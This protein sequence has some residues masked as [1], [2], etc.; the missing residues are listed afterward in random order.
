[1]IPT[2]SDICTK[3][4]VS[5][6][7]NASI[8]DAI[9]LMGSKNVRSVVILE[10]EENHCF[11]F[12]INNAIEYKI[13][14]LPMDTKLIDLQLHKAQNIDANISILEL[15]NHRGLDHEYF[16][17]FKEKEIIGI[18]SQTDIIN[19]ID[20]QMLLQKQS[21]ASIMLQYTVQTVYA[22]EA[23]INAIKIMKNENIDSVIIIDNTHQ[24]IGIFTTKDFL[25][26]VSE[27]IDLTLPI[28]NYMSFPLE[29]LSKDVKIYEALE[30][31]RKKRFK[32]L[33]VT[34][35]NSKIS[36]VITQSELLR[37]IN[38][39]WMEIIRD[40]GVELSKQNEELMKKA[41]RLEETAS[42]DF[43]TKLFNRRKF[44]ALLQYEIEQVK[45]YQKGK[46]SMILLDID[47]FKSINDTYGHDIGDEILKE[48]GLMLKRLSRNS[49]V[50]SRWGGEEFALNLS[51][52]PIEDALFVAEKLRASIQEHIFTQNLRITCS[53][54]V[55]QFRTSDELS[56]LFKRADEA[57][58]EAK[59]TGK[60]K[61]VLERL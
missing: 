26:I 43:L 23:T 8:E 35:E 40:R 28:K 3:E 21:I 49:D 25:N 30:F 55:S 4:I 56:D 58:Y 22:N 37:L 5:I 12:S 6:D 9:K 1:M 38:N 33:I 24:P 10:Q 61:V 15:T 50:V 7:I 53:F 41:S 60:N 29:T 19:N 20:P 14:N 52:T 54:G 44:D 39:K 42:Q 31:I 16:I 47:N 48:L 59:N 51:Y 11:I 46:L 34:D 27:T 57:L 18:L 2:V 32:R 36:G 13:Q 17:V 45:R